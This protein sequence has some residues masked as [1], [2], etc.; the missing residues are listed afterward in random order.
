M[1]E[2]TP[3]APRGA[4][5]TQKGG[6][7]DY[8]YEFQID[9]DVYPRVRITYAG[10]IFVGDG[11]ANPT[12]D[13][14]AGGGTAGV[15]SFNTRTGAVTLA[16]TDVNSALGYTA[17]DAATVATK[18]DNSAVVHVTGNE[19][20]GGIKTFTSNPVVPAGAFPESATANLVA[21]LAAK[22]ADSAVVHN[23]GTETIAGAKTFS[24]APVVPSASFPESAVINLTTDL[25]AKAADA[26]VVHNTGAES[27]AG[28]KTFT[29]APVVPTNSFPES[30]VTN[31]VADLASR[32]STTSSWAKHSTT[33]SIPNAAHTAITWDTNVI[34]TLGAHSTSVNP[35]RFT[36][37]STGIYEIGCLLN[38]GGANA[39]TAGYLT[40]DKN[41]S[42]GGTFML[43]RLDGVA[44][45]LNLNAN[46]IQGHTIVSLTAG[47]Y[48][49]FNAYQ[50][51]GGAINLSASDGGGGT[52]VA[53]MRQVT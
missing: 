34:N 33:Q 51:S 29:S 20:V 47:D 35:T 24:T 10:N 32:A 23:T 19:N 13:I 2:K 38:F 36:A 18:A 16:G 50:A 25:A 7:T 52:L 42:G 17:G 28:V 43:G 22:A 12:T 49:V 14:A 3:A 8:A 9:G 44:G 48:I 27:V 40:Y 5:L 11:T 1:A 31:L 21:D 26:A 30:A 39:S 45:G 15:A 37:P 46:T 41:A 53:Y 4:V 6:K